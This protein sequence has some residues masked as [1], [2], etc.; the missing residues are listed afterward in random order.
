MPSKIPTSF[1]KAKHGLIADRKVMRT[2]L[3]QA[4]NHRKVHQQVSVIK[5]FTTVNAL[6]KIVLMPTTSKAKEKAKA[7][8]KARKEKESLRVRTQVKANTKA[9]AKVNGTEEREVANLLLPNHHA[10]PLPLVAPHHQA[11]QTQLLVDNGNKADTATAKQLSHILVLTGTKNSVTFG[12]NQDCIANLATDATSYMPTS[13]PV[14][15]TPC[16]N[17]AESFLKAKAAKTRAKARTH[18]KVKEKARKV[19][20]KI[21]AKAK[22]KVSSKAKAKANLQQHQRLNPKPKPRLRPRPK[23]EVMPTSPSK[24]PMNKPKT[25][26]SMIGKLTTGKLMH[27]TATPGTVTNGIPMNGTQANGRIQLSR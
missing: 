25:I 1:D 21:R 27:G 2:L 26:K 20:A 7:R 11:K 24:E 19:K 15:I 6:D 12:C 8:A 16:E 13:T 14:R 17:Q 18:P 10:K 3:P 5:P 4:R 9:K 23:R 22:A